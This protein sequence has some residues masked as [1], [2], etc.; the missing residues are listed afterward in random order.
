M[1]DIF[2]IPFIFHDIDVITNKWPVA[3]VEN[4]SE[5]IHILAPINTT[6]IFLHINLLQEPIQGTPNYLIIE[7]KLP[8]IE[9]SSKLT[10]DVG[11]D[12]LILHAHPAK[13]FLDVEMPYDVVPMKSGSQYDTENQLLTVALMTTSGENEAGKG[14]VI[15]LDTKEWIEGLRSGGR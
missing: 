8:G 7:I 5:K 12:R 3:N 1:V 4:Y 15:T 2:K 9:S 10:L 13:Y 14:R 6:C 11:E